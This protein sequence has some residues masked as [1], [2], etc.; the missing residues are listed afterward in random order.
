MSTRRL[1]PGLLAVLCVSCLTHQAREVEGRVVGMDWHILGECLGEPQEREFDPEQGDREV[2]RYRML[3]FGQTVDV[4]IDFRGS[5]G[6]E[7]TG[8]SSTGDQGYVPSRGYCSYEFV[9]QGET[10]SAVRAEGRDAGGM[11][12][13]A[14]CMRKLRPCVPERPPLR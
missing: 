8:V 10:V 14:R 11:N 6:R 12:A 3:N 7:V 13:D 2:W 9:I 5:V 1:L 4:H